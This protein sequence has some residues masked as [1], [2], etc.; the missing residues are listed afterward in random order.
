MSIRRSRG[1]TP[2]VRSLV[3][4]LLGPAIAHGTTYAV[5]VRWEPSPSEG[6]A[7]YRVAV[8]ARTGGS[9]PVLDAGLPPPAAD[10]SL[11]AQ[12]SGLDGR[13]DYDVT[14]T[15]Y[16][17]AGLESVPS[18]AIAIGYAQVAANIDTDGDGLSD[19]TEDPNL[20][21]VVDP[22]ETS[23]LSADTDGDG[24]GDASDL[25]QGTPAGT[26]VDASGCPCTQATCGTG[27][28]T[29]WPDTAAPVRA[30]RGADS[31][32]E[33][34]VKFR[35]DVPGYVRGIR[36]YKHVL[37][38]GT[39]VGNLW[40]SAGTRLAT[41][42]FSGESAS[43]WQQVIFSSPVAI[44]ADTTYVASYHCP[45]GHFSFDVGY[46]ATQGVDRPPLHALSSPE[47]GGNDVYV[48]GATSGFPTLTYAATNYWVDV[49]FSPTTTP[50]PVPIT[51]TT[52]ALPDGTVGM[53]YTTTLAASGGTPPYT[54][55]VASGGLPPGLALDATTGVIAG[56]PTAS[57]VS[58]FAVQAS[59]GTQSASRTLTITV[60]SPPSSEAQ[61]IWPD[62]TVPGR[63]DGG[64]DAAVELGV[65]FRADVAGY[66]TG[67]R[68]Y[69]DP[70][71]TGTHVGN[72]WSST[73][74]RLATA[75]FSG[76]SASGWQQVTFPS[77]V[78][79]A[80]DTVYVAS[81]LCPNGHYSEDDY[82]FS[83]EGVDR[84]PLHALAD[85]EAGRNSVFVYVYGATSRFPTQTWRAANYWVDVMFTPASALTSS[86][87]ASSTSTLGGVTLGTRPPESA[88][89]G[90]FENT[91]LRE[92]GR[93]R[94]RIRRF[95]LRRA[96]GG[97]RLT[98][99][100]RFAFPAGLDLRAAGI[101][102][103]LEDAAHRPLLAVALDG[104]DLEGIPGGWQTSANPPGVE[105]FVVRRRGRHVIVRLRG[106]LTEAGSAE[107]SLSWRVQF[108]AACADSI[109][110]TCSDEGPGRRRCRRRP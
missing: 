29:I 87:E 23:A 40:S 51:I 5:R 18:N 59:A 95:A 74:T 76:E 2:V 97:Y 38:T 53:A 44:A 6:V 16:T 17:S 1:T 103:T 21:R 93:S 14:V 24:V 79:I 33:L 50:P 12:V 57:G 72:L 81:Y 91:A 20:N 88:A 108:G 8:Q 58:T 85:G 55:T 46:F 15:A 56:T 82:Y 105:R 47:A 100:G 109:E 10:G 34:G 66:V 80:A 90:R 106:R 65:K 98:A 107:R 48:Y 99:I 71:N 22:G 26:S 25:C 73:G 41:A 83:G 68:F 30:D 28:S 37:N 64:P 94:A 77:P 13:T 49:V 32:V 101:T 52:T 31:A 45:N 102:T 39:H 67:I 61:T 60:D 27:D 9:L 78:A 4:L 110:L 19:A 75:T 84:P 3:A 54:W 11:A 96:G 92:C 62:T 104:S 89:S 7:G 36:F 70:L 35:S 42:T 63:T 69:K 86:L 43:G